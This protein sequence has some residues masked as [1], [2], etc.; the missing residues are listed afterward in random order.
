MYQKI[1]CVFILMMLLSACAVGPDYKR[2][3][4]I[5]PLKFKEA[6]KGWKLA[7]PCD[8]F[9]RGEWW[10]IFHDSQLNALESSLNI[11]N[12]NVLMVAE[13]YRQAVFLVDEA[14]AAYFPTVTLTP[15]VTRQRQVSTSQAT[16]IPTGSSAG[17]SAFGTGKSS[18]VT[19]FHTLLLTGTWEPDLWGGI[20]RSVEASMANAQASAAL[21]EV[22][23]LSAQASLAQYYFELRGVDRDIQLLND[24]IV[25][26]KKI[27]QY[28]RNRYASGVAGRLDVVQAQAQLETAQ[29]QAINLGVTRSQYEHAIATLIGRPA[30]LFAL[31]AKRYHFTPPTVPLVV[32][33]SLLERRPDIAQAERLMAQANAQIGV[34]IAAYYPTLT[35]NGSANSTHKGLEHWFSIPSTAWALSAQLAE[36]LIDGGLRIATAEAARANYK[37]TV[38]SYRQVVLAAFQDT[39]DNLAA[40]RILKSEE[41]VLYKAAYDTRKALNITI[42]EYKAGT[43]DF[44][45]VMIAQN[46]ALAAEKTAIDTL[47]LRMSAIVGLIKSL[48]GG[49]DAHEI[50]NAGCPALICKTVKPC[51]VSWEGRRSSREIPRCGR[52]DKRLEMTKGSG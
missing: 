3:S 31:P 21:I 13:Q 51:V 2:P 45:Q 8:D 16:N 38:A 24:T 11:N 37:A 10:R 7:N 36:V 26:Y 17:F 52:D 50:D 9:H 15:S 49:W 35:L 25:D 12:Q 1:S 39:E 33:S 32:P 41:N 23:R 19:T 22:T 48:G 20:R 5:V 14:R 18:S 44:S 42:N 6:P 43:V 47:Y 40:V 29:G 27:L 46:A 34:A 4:V 30:S 28:T